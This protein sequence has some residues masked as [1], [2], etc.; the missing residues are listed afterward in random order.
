M[1]RVRRKL[2]GNLI[3]CVALSTQVV[4]R[5]IDYI[6]QRLPAKV[7]AH[8]ATLIVKTVVKFLVADRTGSYVKSLGLCLTK[9]R[10]GTTP[11][12]DIVLYCIKNLVIQ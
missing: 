8:S 2:I 7:V 11:T 10:C 6:V 9:N 5:L 3:D 1:N 12:S 4:D